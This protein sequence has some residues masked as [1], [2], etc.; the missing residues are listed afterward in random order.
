MKQLL[1]FSRAG[2]TATA[3]AYY[4]YCHVVKKFLDEALLRCSSCFNKWLI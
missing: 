4:M 2:P 1:Y 3:H